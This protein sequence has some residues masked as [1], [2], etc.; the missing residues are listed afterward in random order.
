MRPWNCY[1]LVRFLTELKSVYVLSFH[2][3]IR[4]PIHM[5]KYDVPR[6]LFDISKMAGTG[7]H[8]L[9]DSLTRNVKSD[10]FLIVEIPHMS[11]LRGCVRFIINITF[12]CSCIAHSFAVVS[13][14]TLRFTTWLKPTNHN[15]TLT[16]RDTNWPIRSGLNTQHFSIKYHVKIGT[17]FDPWTIMQVAVNCSNKQLEF[18]SRDELSS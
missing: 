12:R 17:I 10:I 4:S 1:E 5:S 7:I 9:I 8:Y 11:A 15:T 14:G 3:S 16:P 13:C 18:S 6:R 2:C